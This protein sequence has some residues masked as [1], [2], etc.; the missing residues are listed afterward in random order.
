MEPKIEAFTTGA[1]MSRRF[2]ILGLGLLL[3]ALVFF[4]N[5]GAKITASH[6]LCGSPDSPDNPVQKYKVVVNAEDQHSIWP[7]DRENPLGWRDAGFEGTKCECIAHVAKVWESMRPS[8]TPTA[9]PIGPSDFHIP[10]LGQNGR[11]VEIKGPFDGD[12]RTTEIRVDGQLVTPLAESSKSCF[13]IVPNEKF[14]STG[15]TVQERHVEATGTCRILSVELTADKLNLRSGEKS[16]VLI[17]VKGGKGIQ[18]N[19]PLQLETTG[20]VNMDGGN[21]QN[22]QL[23]PADFVIEGVEV[24]A[25]VRKVVVGLHPGVFNVTATVIDPRVRPLVVP[26]SD[27]QYE[28]KKEGPAFVV[29]IKNVKHPITSEPLDGKHKLEYKCPELSKLPLINNLLLNKGIGRTESQCLN[30]ATPRI[31]I[32]EEEN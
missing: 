31:I 11:P 3:P 5:A 23:R 24:T 13:F 14:G 32:S 2:L 12:V 10:D 1:K 29:R 15:I 4:S 26:L 6:P 8:P 28:V 17:K 30:M 7:N 16:N 18:Q 19:V 20:A 21:I 9:T 27:R 22:I 25:N